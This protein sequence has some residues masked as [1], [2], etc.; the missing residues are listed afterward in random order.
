MN[1]SKGS[2]WRLSPE[3]F[4]TSE[5]PS[6]VVKGLLD[7]AVMWSQRNMPSPPLDVKKNLYHTTLSQ[8]HKSANLLTIF[9]VYLVIVR[10]I[11]V[12]HGRVHFVCRQFHLIV[13]NDCYQTVI[14]QLLQFIEER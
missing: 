14:H 9:P 5:R 13:W 11:R 6:G 2:G 7:R 8:I 1:K 12:S 10:V 4:S 3:A